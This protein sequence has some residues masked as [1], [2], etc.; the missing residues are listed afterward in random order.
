MKVVAALFAG[1]LLAGCASQPE[2]IDS[3]FTYQDIPSSGGVA[4]RA[5]SLR[6]GK[7]FEVF[8]ICSTEN[9]HYFIR[10]TSTQLFGGDGEKWSVNINGGRYWTG[11]TRYDD[12]AFLAAISTLEVTRPAKG[13][14]DPQV[15]RVT[16]AKL[17][18][19]PEICKA[20]SAQ[21]AAT[22]KT[23]ADS[24]RDENARLISEVVKRTG[25][26]PMLSGRNQMDFNNLILLFQRNGISNY[27]EKFVWVNDGD[28]RI[29]Q[30]MHNRVLLI[31]MTNPNQFPAITIITQD[32]AIEGQF[33]S[34]VSHGPLQLSGVSSYMT[35]IGVSRQTIVFKRI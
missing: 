10:Q 8:G 13:F 26:Q 24:E 6:A 18:S 3:D 25:V 31:S 33:W 19:M 12:E 30:V 4:V 27:L 2:Y 1:L 21:I 17:E 32:P 15:M 20:K 16:N 28:Y 9:R 34:S 14:S 11:E 7:T 29:A 23:T 35:S 22:I 5:S